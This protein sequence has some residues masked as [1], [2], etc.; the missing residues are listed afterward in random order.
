MEVKEKALELVVG[1]SGVLSSFWWL[2]VHGQIQLEAC[3]RLKWR[4]L[5]GTCRRFDDNTWV[6]R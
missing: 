1:W 3:A 4:E 2:C 5:A 6:Q